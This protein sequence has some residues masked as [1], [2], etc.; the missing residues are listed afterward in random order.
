MLKKSKSL[1]KSLFGF[2]LLIV[3]IIDLSKRCVNC[4]A[5]LREPICLYCGTDYGVP[6]Q[7]E[8]VAEVSPPGGERDISFQGSRYKILGQLAEGENC[9]VYVARRHHFVKEQIVVKR[10]EGGRALRA[11]WS[12]LSHLSG[13]CSYL[14]RLLPRPI[15]LRGIRSGRTVL[16]YGW[17]SGFVHTLAYVSKQYPSGVQPEASVWI[18][19]RLLEQLSCLHQLGYSHNGLKLE[20]CLIHPRDHGIALCGWSRAA[21]GDGQDL[22]AS[23]RLIGELLGPRAPQPLLEL[24]RSAHQ[25]YRPEQLLEEVRRVARSVFGPP[26]YRSFVLG[27]QVRAR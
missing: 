19:N 9:K 7:I 3:S 26:Q 10:S 13:R 27:P 11:E 17:R 20:N 23:G 25:F 22:A 24:A 16:A 14:D 15:E 6:R 12:T 4:G 21:L 1:T 5:P 2:I 18:W 8:P